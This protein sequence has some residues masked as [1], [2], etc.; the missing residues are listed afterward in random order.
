M[1]I[2]ASPWCIFPYNL[3]QIFYPVWSYWHFFRNS[4]WRPPPSWIFSLCEFSHSGVLMV[5]FLSSVPNLVQLS[6]VV[7]EIDAL[8]CFR[9]SFDDV[10]RINFR[11]RLLVMWS[12]PR[13]GDWK[14]EN[15]KRGTVKN[16]GVENAGLENAAPVCRGWK[17]RDRMLW[18]AENVVC[19][20]LLTVS[21]SVL[22]F[23]FFCLILYGALQCLWHDSVTLISTLLII[24]QLRSY[25]R[26]YHRPPF[27]TFR[28]QGPRTG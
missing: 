13:G 17:M 5:W 15:G 20:R 22:L 16:A 1:I 25:D 27:T 24:I 4:R 2:S 23:V 6:V 11:F 3:V 7:T 9:H 10:T 12:S 8:V 21:A 28:E 19:P 14:Y 26:F 18:N